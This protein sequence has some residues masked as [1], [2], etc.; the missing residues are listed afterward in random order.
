MSAYATGSQESVIAVPEDARLR[1][2]QHAQ[3]SLFMAAIDP[4]HC[5]WEWSCSGRWKCKA[6]CWFC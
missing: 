2:R 4:F 1:Q 6:Y 5:D 3:Q